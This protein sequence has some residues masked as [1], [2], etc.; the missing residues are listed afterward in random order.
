MAPSRSPCKA[1]AKK[2]APKSKAEL[3]SSDSEPGDLAYPDPPQT[4]K[5]PTRHAKRGL[6]PQHESPSPKKP[7]TKKAVPRSPTPV[8]DGSDAGLEDDLSAGPGEGEDAEE[9]EELEEVVDK[10]AEEVDE[11]EEASV[12][13]AGDWDLEAFFDHTIPVAGRANYD[14][15]VPSLPPYDMSGVGDID[16]DPVLDSLSFYDQFTLPNLVY[17]PHN[18]VD[19]DAGRCLEDTTG[20]VMTMDTWKELGVVY[21]GATAPHPRSISL[22]KLMGLMGF[23]QSYSV[24]C[25]ATADPLRFKAKFVGMFSKDA[26]FDDTIKWEAHLN[27][28]TCTFVDFGGIVASHLTS[29]DPSFGGGIRHVQIIDHTWFFERKKAFFNTFFRKE[30]L[31]IRL[32]E[33]TI[34]SYETRTP[35]SN[36]EP[37]KFN[38]STLFPPASQKTITGSPGKAATAGTFSSAGTR[39]RIFS[40]DDTI[41]IYDG[42]GKNLNNF[43]MG[44]DLLNLSKKLPL[45]KGEAPSRS[46]VMVGYIAHGFSWRGDWRLKFYVQWVVVLA[47]PGKSMN[48]VLSD[49]PKK[50]LSSPNKKSIPGSPI[51][52][53]GTTK[54]PVART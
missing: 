3:D 18:V 30:E 29:V 50:P 42:T 19:A 52:Q 11:D 24:A 54:K 43:K 14:F 45:W 41:P 26:N 23:T 35:L 6:S 17:G 37:R 31:K 15:V 16:K 8:E 21:D 34:F 27:N 25:P 49:S 20:T 47:V 44:F 7:R 51:K 38:A 2:T 36:K 22:D 10:F 40:P 12:G 53:S 4:P 39:P 46:L 13:E 48:D 1:A 9:A 5:R 33:N 28:Y 32:T